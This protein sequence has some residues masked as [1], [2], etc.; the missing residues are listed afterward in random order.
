[1]YEE[2]RLNMIVS[3]LL[4]ACFKGVSSREEKESEHKTKLIFN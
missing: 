1:M 2:K 4:S 3:A